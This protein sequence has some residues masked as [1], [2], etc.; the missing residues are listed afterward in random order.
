M[1]LLGQQQHAAAAP[2]VVIGLIVAILIFVYAVNT[3]IKNHRTFTLQE[4]ARAYAGEVEPATWF[5]T[6]SMT[7]RHDGRIVT[8]SY[9]YGGGKYAKYKTHLTIAWPDNRLRCEIFPASVFSGLRKLIGMQDIEIGS[10]QFD[11][12]FIVTGND[13]EAIKKFLTPDAQRSLIQLARMSSGLVIVYHDFYL[14]ISRGVLMMTKSG[15][16]SERHILELFIRLFLEFFDATQPS[17]SGIEFLSS[18]NVS[19]SEQPHCV[20]CGEPLSNDIVSCRACR[21]PHH[22]DC[23]QYFGGCGTYGCGEKRYT[24]IRPKVPA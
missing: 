9:T 20:V 16:V 6:P 17:L 21:T 5:S 11:E 10:P 1:M 7:F 14:Q 23:W 15:Y 24:A 3:G 12:P 4:V 22:L 2:I 8:L 19:A 18:A 13:E